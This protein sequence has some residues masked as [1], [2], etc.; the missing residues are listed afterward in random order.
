MI[1]KPEPLNLNIYRKERCIS[2]LFQNDVGDRPM[3]NFRGVQ[4]GESYY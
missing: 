3:S 4:L 2:A 1:P